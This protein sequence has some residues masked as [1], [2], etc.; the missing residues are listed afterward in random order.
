MP[1]GCCSHGGACN[2]QEA[3]DAVAWT[4]EGT[5]SIEMM[6]FCGYSSLSLSKNDH[7]AGASN[8]SKQ[9]RVKRDSVSSITENLNWLKI[10]GFTAI[11]FC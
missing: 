7:P 5:F 6:S 4:E 1:S 10:A 3:R 11:L 9:S 2:S 8:L